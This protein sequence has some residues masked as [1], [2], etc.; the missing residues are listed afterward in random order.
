MPPPRSRRNLA[1]RI[2]V[3]PNDEAERRAAAKEL[4]D[5]QLLRSSDPPCSHQ[6]LPRDRSSRLLDC[7][8]APAPELPRN[9][10]VEVN[11]ECSDP[12]TAPCRSACVEERRDLGDL[13]TALAQM[14]NV[15]PRRPQSGPS[16]SV[17]LSSR[18]SARCPTTLWTAK[19]RAPVALA[20]SSYLRFFSL[21]RWR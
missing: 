18:V 10:S 2:K 7:L 8:T 6:P 21:W 13:N 20:A 15:M 12:Q 3:A 16:T 19:R 5:H 9:D 4:F 11:P 14:L 17:L 1:M